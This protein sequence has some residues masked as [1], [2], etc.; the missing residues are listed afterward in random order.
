M[1]VNKKIE[2]MLS[3]VGI[4]L[5]YLQFKPYKNKPVPSP[6]YLIYLISSERGYGPDDRNLIT[7]KRVAVELY[8]NVKDTQ[9]EKKV[10]S[11]LSAYEYE[12]SEDYIESENMYM[13][14]Y[15]FNIYEK[16][17]R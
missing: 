15:D 7:Q 11:A 2:E 4:P 8:S 5:A 3:T 10:E 14:T 9:L 13:V 17:R 16:I 1:V 6:P 12:K